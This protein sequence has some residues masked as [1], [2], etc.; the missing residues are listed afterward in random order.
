M[1]KLNLDKS[2]VRIFCKFS[3]WQQ[4]LSRAVNIWQ[5]LP[6]LDLP[7]DRYL[8]I[9]MYVCTLQRVLLFDQH[10]LLFSSYSPTCAYYYVI[11][12]KIWISWHNI[13]TLTRLQIFFCQNHLIDRLN[14]LLSGRVHLHLNAMSV[15]CE[16]LY[17]IFKAI[18][19]SFSP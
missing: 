12:K 11:E 10:A 5:C 18:F 3:I 19:P 17:W 2:P 15:T 8:Q 1:S 6:D 14:H 13:V 9:S 4:S 7:A 16:G